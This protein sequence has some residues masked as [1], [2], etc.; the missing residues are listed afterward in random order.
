LRQHRRRGGT[1][2]RRGRRKSKRLSRQVE[3]IHSTLPILP[4]ESSLDEHYAEIGAALEAGGNPIGP[5]HLLIAADAGAFGLTLATHNLAEV[6]RVP[7]LA[8]KNWLEIG[9]ENRHRHGRAEF[10]ETLALPDGII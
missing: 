3:A 1:S 10:L 5:N 6:L 9:L 4:L 7:G 2:L 8:M